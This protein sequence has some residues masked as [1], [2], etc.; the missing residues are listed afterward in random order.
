MTAPLYPDVPTD[1]ELTNA[2]TGGVP[3]TDPHPAL[4]KRLLA[5]LRPVRAT[6]ASLKTPEQFG[7]VGDGVADDAPALK[8]MLASLEPGDVVRAAA[9]YRHASVLDDTQGAHQANGYTITGGGTFRATVP[10]QAA[11]KVHGN[12]VTFDNVRLLL[13]GRTGR[14]DTYESEKFVI[15]GDNFTAHR[16]HSEG[17]SATGFF[18]TGVDGF[19]LIQCSVRDTLADGIHIT[20]GSKNGRVIRPIV[21]NSGDDGVA[22]VSYLDGF[23]P[24]LCENIT[25]WDPRCDGSKAGRGVACVGGKNIAFIN[26]WTNNTFAAGIYI[27]RETGVYNTYPFTDVR[28]IGQH[29]V[30]QANTNVDPAGVAGPVDHGAVMISNMGPATTSA[31]M[32]GPLLIEGVTTYDTRATNPWEVGFIGTN[33]GVVNITGTVIRRMAFVNGPATFYGT[34]TTTQQ[35]ATSVAA[36][37]KTYTNFRRYDWTRSTTATAT[38][39]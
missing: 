28:V 15:Y 35:Q 6:V 38:A 7:A 9:I 33:G 32:C 12:D 21:E 24:G 18:L 23:N 14:N 8:A 5:A 3:I 10:A 11:F 20:G 4:L 13:V 17:G 31:Q 1:T 27:A 37:G 30:R 36:D 25:V 39:A 34:Q 16:V 22:V 19:T 26:V 29:T 2:L